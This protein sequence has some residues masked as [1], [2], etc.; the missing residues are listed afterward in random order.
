MLDLP[1]YTNES[2][3]GDEGVRA[4]ERII[5][6]QFNWI[7]R[8]Q[9]KNDFGIDAHLEILTDSRKAT[10]VLM[11]LQIKCG[12]SFFNEKTEDGYIYRGSMKHLNYW[13]HHS[14]AVIITITNPESGETFWAQ[15]TRANAQFI[16]ATWKIIIPYTQILSVKAKKTLIDIASQVTDKDIIELLLPRFLYEKY[17]RKAYVIPFIEAPHDVHGTTEIMMLSDEMVY[18]DFYYPYLNIYN[19]DTVKEKLDLRDSNDVACGQK[20]RK[21]KLMMFFIAE[22]VE[23]LEV[24][25]NVVNLLKAY[26]N[27]EYF[28]LVYR[29]EKVL[30]DYRSMFLT[31]ID[32]NG[33]DIWQYD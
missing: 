16:G 33:I 22:S 2:E 23:N 25:T 26:E 11:A 10:G 15:V 9:P 5:S 17:G 8:E 21:T 4:V 12:K 32:E 6:K 24:P 7:F 28:R 30:T 3:L 18:F 14:L 19:I 31:E 29:N 1:E 20:N 27:I 13:L